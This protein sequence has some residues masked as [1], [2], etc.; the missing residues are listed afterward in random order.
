VFARVRYDIPPEV[1]DRTNELIAERREKGLTDTPPIPRVKELYVGDA[2]GRRLAHPVT[3]E[4]LAARA[5]GGPEMEG[6]GDPREKLFQWLVRPDNPYLARAFVNR[7][8]GHYFGRGLVDPVDDF[9]VGNPAAN[10]RLLDALAKDFVAGGFK[11]RRLERTI[12]ASRVYQLSS[13]PTESNRHDRMLNSHALPRPMLAEVVVDV[14]NSALG[15]TEDVGSDAPPGSRAIDVGT[16]F[17]RSAPLGQMFRLFGR[18]I[19]S[20]ACDC[21]RPRDAAV[22]QTLFLMV[23][24]IILRKIATGRLKGLLASKLT[25]AEVVEELF[26]ATLSRLPEAAESK[27]ALEAVGRAADRKAGFADVLWA[28]VNTREFILNH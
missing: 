10:E 25:D 15:T 20:A 28:L 21:E 19:R 12:L 7:L 17:V 14:L 23:D 6:P 5:L 9:S 1:R 2:P 3:N 22:N 24:P 11:I 16:N 13:R 8:W 18:P 27:A 4:F 26:L